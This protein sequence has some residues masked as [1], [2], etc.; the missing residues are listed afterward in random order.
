MCKKVFCFWSFVYFSFNFKFNKY[1]QIFKFK[2]KRDASKLSTSS[3]SNASESTL[4]AK[5]TKTQIEKV[6]KPLAQKT[7][8]SNNKTSQIKSQQKNTQIDSLDTHSSS[9]SSSSISSSSKIGSPPLKTFSNGIKDVEFNLL[10]ENG[11]GVVDMLEFS[12]CMCK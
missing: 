2:L 3:L 6:A 7:S 10:S 9:S 5:K 4:V 8:L 11:N 1:L 12:C